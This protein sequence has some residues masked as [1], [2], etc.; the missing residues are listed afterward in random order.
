[1]ALF[2]AA[3]SAQEQRG[4]I[5]GIVKDA[6]GGVLPGVTVTLKSAAGA[7]LE[8]VTDG[9][10]V[11]RFPAV[12]P[13]T[14]TVV[15]ALSGF[16][17]QTM[18]DV[19]VTLGQVRRVEFTL[20]IEGMTETVQVTATTSGVDLSTAATATSITRERIDFLP[21]GRDFT[22]VI[23][24]AAGAAPESQS[25]GISV[26]GASGSE[27]RF[28]ID[29]IDTT[30]PQVGTNS[31]PMRAEFMEEI[32]VKSAGYA[33]EFGGSTGGVINAVTRSGSNK[34]SGTV[35]ADYQNRSWGGDS[36]G[37]L[38]DSLTSRT[39]EYITPPKDDETR[40]D[41]GFSLG[42]PIL[43]DRLWFFGSYQPGIRNTERTV[44]F[45][46]GVTNT[47][48]QDF[49]VQ[50]GAVNVTGNTGPKLIYRVGANLSPYTTE[51]DLPTQTGRT[52]LTN[53]SQYVRGTEG[54]RNT[55]S[56]SADWVPT[57]RLTVS[58]RAGR[59]LTDL[60]SLN[61]AFPG[62]IMQISTA[63]TPAG[64]A[65]LPAGVPRTSG[66]S[67]DVLIGDA[68]ARDEYIR[69]YIGVDATYIFDGAG[70]HQL[71]G[72]F[73]T[74]RIANDVKTG[75][76]A[77]RIIHYAGL[78]YTTSSGERRT[79]TYG[80]FRLLNISTLGDVA[81]RN[82]ALFV[83]DAWS[84]RPN[85]ILNLG[86]R[87]EHEKVP[88]FGAEGVAN[89]IEFNYGQKLA[90]R[91]GFTWDPK[92]DGRTKLYGSWGKYFD[93]MKYE[94]PRGAF[95]GDK[96]V[97][98]YY[99][100]DNPDVNVNKAA[101]CATGSNTIA[102]RPSCPGG[103]L[104]EVFDQ[105]HNAAEDLDQYV[106][107]NLKP[108]EEHELQLGFSRELTFRGVG[109]VVVGARYIRKDLKRAIEDV[110]VN[111]EGVGTTY[112]IA[113]P[114]EG[115]TLAL[116]DPSIPAFP[117]AKRQYDGIEFTLD[118]RFSKK[119]GAFGS[120]TYSRLYGN[121]SGLASS[122]ENGR[123]A[124]NVNRFFDHIENMF[125]ANGDLVY[126]RLGTDRPH[127]FKGQ[128]MYQFT[129]LTTLGLNQR[130][131]SGIPVSE[132]AN[133]PV[134][135]PFFPYGRGNLGRTPVLSQ[136]D[137]SVFQDVKTGMGTSLQFGVTVLNLF[138]QNTITRYD[139]TRMVADLPV[140]MT[141]FFNGGWDYEALLQANPTSVDPKFRQADQF[142]A[143]REIRFTV[144]F[145]F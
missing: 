95:G 91:L 17:T 6:S 92:S 76:N 34:F 11:Y 68:T 104:I 13:T 35:L 53:P 96:W 20:A 10:G 69:D 105:R 117:K 97:D 122:D 24:Q 90:P 107:P 32:Q 125:D 130:V 112:Y 108:M 113:N 8:A 67:S 73:Q 143:P 55:F 31:V 15:A 106:E 16:T 70:Q 77:D 116:N 88:N 124:P 110:G 119:W 93:V 81:S 62:S 49:K 63:S 61:V 72:G 115:I 40:V 134:G 123:T 141:Q 132:E 39:Y 101:G 33:A 100:W 83:Q 25:G 58:G 51:G 145:Q 43:R 103:S 111:V 48:P 9:E 144:K 102:E 85:L 82:N 135:V 118:R 2:G 140:T 139:N 127:Q 120:Y 57:N 87:A 65:A 131:A 22:D 38:V 12:A 7:T 78:S 46:N 71:K 114:G 23:G 41:P 66:Y 86:L 54:D 79:G 27:N 59:F 129:S 42:G 109:G 14:Y 84:V 4:S 18:A 52:S 37:I 36:R 3:A 44:K 30:S 137:L 1:L 75:Y 121:Y 28:V 138:D 94:M 80:Y 29:G 47:F 99:T 89:P 136:T 5:E 128:F 45:S 21:R 19:Q 98:Y 56:G 142:Q 60:R 50:Y 64:L 74:E 26:N 126:G 133:V